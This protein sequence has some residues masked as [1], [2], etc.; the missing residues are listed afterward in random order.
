MDHGLVQ[1]QWQIISQWLFNSQ[2]LG[3]IESGLSGSISGNH[4][5]S[6]LVL[7]VAAK[8]LLFL[9]LARQKFR[10]KGKPQQRCSC[11]RNDFL[12]AAYIFICY[13]TATRDFTYFLRQ[14]HQHGKTDPTYTTQKQIDW[15]DLLVTQE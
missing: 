10:R 15:R 3:S 14:I 5:L 2:S 11:G 12:V 9:R 7:I 8:A 1:D 4:M 6:T 13:S